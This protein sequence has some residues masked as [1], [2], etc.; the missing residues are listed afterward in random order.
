M[1]A[2]RRDWGPH[3]GLP[4]SP[5]LQGLHGTFSRQGSVLPSASPSP[6]PQWR[7]GDFPGK[8]EADRNL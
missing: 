8:G 5:S 1:A 4:K 6:G 3:R 7:G 2:L